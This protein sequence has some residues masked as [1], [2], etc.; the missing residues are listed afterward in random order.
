MARR[1]EH[2]TDLELPKPI[3]PFLPAESLFFAESPCVSPYASNVRSPSLTPFPLFTPNV[4]PVISYDT[5]R[6]T[7]EFGQR[8]FGMDTGYRT[9]GCMKTDDI[10]DVFVDQTCR[11]LTRTAQ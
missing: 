8:M 2:P 5:T 10:M 9:P 7:K 11:T 6:R 4:P 1:P 3:S